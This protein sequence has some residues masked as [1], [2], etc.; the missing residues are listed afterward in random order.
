MAML[1]L[2]SKFEPGEIIGLVAVAGGLLCGI[3]CG[4]TAIVMDHL[5]KLR[6][7]ALKQDMINRGMSVD[8][9]Q[10]VLDAGTGKSRK[11]LHGQSSCH[12]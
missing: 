11:A 4:T 9:M 7:L 2:L 5:H 8:E 6:Q 1:E 12:S 3:L 10:V